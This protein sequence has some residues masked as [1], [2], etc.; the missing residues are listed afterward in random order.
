MWRLAV[1]G[2]VA[3]GGATPHESAR[4]D[5]ALGPVLDAVIDVAKQNAK[6]VDVDREKAEVHTAWQIVAITHEATDAYDYRSIGKVDRQEPTKYFARYDIRV[7]GPRPWQVVI[8]AHASRWVDG[9]AKPTQMSDDNPPAWL[10]EKREH[11]FDDINR[12]IHASAIEP[13]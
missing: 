11:M 3:C 6:Q 1:V 4:Y 2:L 9:D 5:T 13:R 7:V 12:R 10:T 8:A